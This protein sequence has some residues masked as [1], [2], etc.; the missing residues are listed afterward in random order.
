MYP[1]Y[2]FRNLLF[3]CHSHRIQYSS[4]TALLS[5]LVQCYAQVSHRTLSWSTPVYNDKLFNTNNLCN[6]NTAFACYMHATKHNA[7]LQHMGGSL[8][9]FL[10]ALA[11]DTGNFQK[12]KVTE[13]SARANFLSCDYMYIPA[14]SPRL[15]LGLRCQ[16]CRT[17]SFTWMNGA[18]TP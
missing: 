18:T 6:L 12:R 10:T 8:T 13:R 9:V 16:Q 14:S 2:T 1:N 11:A 7:Q 3:H 5:S 15:L 17:I 4:R